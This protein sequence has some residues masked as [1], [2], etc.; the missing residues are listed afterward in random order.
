[1]K[2][3]RPRSTLLLFSP[4][5]LRDTRR[6]RI[7]Q[8]MLFA[9]TKLIALLAPKRECRSSVSVRIENTN[10]TPDGVKTR[11]PWRHTEMSTHP[12]TQTCI[13]ESCFQV[14]WPTL[15]NYS[16]SCTKME[17]SML[18]G[19]ENTPSISTHTATEWTVN[20]TSYAPS[21]NLSQRSY[22]FWARPVLQCRAKS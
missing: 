22:P 13:K 17:R 15:T 9:K 8:K 7:V 12:T 21:K 4:I 14:V 10:K 20:S 6:S 5:L 11:L 19:I 2:L 3:F 16:F 1:M 18:T